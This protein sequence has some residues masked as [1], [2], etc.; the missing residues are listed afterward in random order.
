M[1]QVE[2]SWHSAAGVGCIRFEDLLLHTIAVVFGT[3]V[4]GGAVIGCVEQVEPF[5]DFLGKWVALN[6]AQRRTRSPLTFL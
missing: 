2:A 6:F 1:F 5:E 4:V 3:F